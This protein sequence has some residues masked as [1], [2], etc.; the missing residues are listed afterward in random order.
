MRETTP[1][2]EG[3]NAVVSVKFVNKPIVVSVVTVRTW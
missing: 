1:A 3:R 2:L